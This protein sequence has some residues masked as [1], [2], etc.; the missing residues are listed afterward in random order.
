MALG[1]HRGR[2]ARVRGALDDHRDGAVE[3]AVEAGGELVVTLPYQPLLGLAQRAHLHRAVPHA[4]GPQRDRVPEHHPRPR[5]AWIET[6]SELLAALHHLADIEIGPDA[7]AECLRRA[8]FNYSYE[9][10]NHDEGALL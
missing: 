3:R 9:T 2:V 8:E 7:F 1:R 5:A 10:P 6:F 4:D